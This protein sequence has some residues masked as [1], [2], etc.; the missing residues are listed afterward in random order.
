MPLPTSFDQYTPQ[1]IQE[2]MF[3]PRQT[4]ST[5]F[6]RNFYR[7]RTILS[8]QEDI[9]FDELQASRKIAP[10][11]IP[12]MP[13]RPI[14]RGEGESIK[15]FRPAYTKPKDSVTPSEHM[16]MTAPEVSRRIPLQTPSQ[17]LA[18]RI[19][20]ITRFHRESIERLW[21]WMY[22]KSLIDAQ[23]PATF[24]TDD[25]LSGKTVTMDFDRLASHTK[26]LS[27]SNDWSANG[28]DII[29]NINDWVDEVADA[30]FGGT[31]TDVL[32]GKTAAKNF[33]QYFSDTNKK[34]RDLLDRN[35]AGADSVMASRGIVRTNPLNPFTYLGQLDGNLQVWKI[36]GPGNQFQNDDD[37]FT[38]IVGV[39]DVVLVSPNVE[40]IMAY[41]AIQDVDFLQPATIWPKT[42]VSQD[43]SARYLMSQSAPLAIPVNPNATMKV[44][45]GGT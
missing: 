45:V 27:S 34:G 13:G 8:T 12:T 43:P 44:T 17:R 15:A 39:N 28:A 32:L 20:N 1:F 9:R 38:D 33:R 14:Y 42:W 40:M 7:S 2:V 23:Y 5:S 25:G 26:D 29:G 19:A 4:I 36:S 31:V 11:M 22:A 6:W 21:D 3:D 35:I 41:G 10:L 37:S 24:M 30:K 18:T 16:Q